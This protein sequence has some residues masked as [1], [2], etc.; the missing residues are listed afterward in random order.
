MAQRTIVLMTCDVHGDETPATDTV[1]FGIGAERFEIDC[2]EAHASEIR[3]TL[4]RYAGLGRKRS[5][6]LTPAAGA[7]KGG[8]GKWGFGAA[9]LSAEEREFAVQQGWAGRGRIRDDIM[10]QLA[11]RRGAA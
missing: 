2:C 6:Q 10:R 5:R 8:G 11:D 1:T 3:S 9:D 7:P 4:A